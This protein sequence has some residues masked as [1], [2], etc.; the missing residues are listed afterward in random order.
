M[1]AHSLTYVELDCDVYRV[2][3]FE[4]ARDRRGAEGLDVAMDPEHDAARRARMPGCRP[5]RGV[6]LLKTTSDAQAL[7]SFGLAPNLQRQLGRR[8][9][10]PAERRR[11]TSPGIVLRG[12]GQAALGTGYLFGVRETDILQ[13]VQ[14]AGGCL[15][16]ARLRAHSTSRPATLLWLRFDAVEHGPRRAVARQGLVWR[17]ERRAGRFLDLFRGY[18]IAVHGRRPGAASTSFSRRGNTSFGH[19]RVRSLLG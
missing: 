19:F 6:R 8:R 10:D 13:I 5:G 7:W 14:L 11:R 1:P 17:A 16:A 12:S 3:Q 18:D 9:H 4:A 15:D 2:T